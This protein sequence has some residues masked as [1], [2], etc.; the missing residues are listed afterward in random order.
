MKITFEPE[1]SADARQRIELGV[2][3][4]NVAATRLPDF[5]VVTFT[6][7]ESSGE[8]RGGLL[9][10]L[11]GGWLHVS[12]LWVETALRRRGWARKL[13]A[14]AERFAIARGA[15]AA[16]LET[17]SFQARRFYEALGYEVFATLD[18]FPPG[19][20]KHFLKKRLTP[21]GRGAARAKGR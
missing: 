19:H 7:R 18:D 6:L 13:L 11:W 17:F 15:G 10:E 20:Q 3:L 5:H 9:G 12:F 14:A 21:G 8:L 2:D 1:L 4:H 16:Q